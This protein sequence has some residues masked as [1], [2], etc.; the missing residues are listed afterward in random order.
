[1]PN[2]SPQGS[3]IAG[4]PGHMALRVERLTRDDHLHRISVCTRLQPRLELTAVM[5]AVCGL[6]TLRWLS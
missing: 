3:S 4:H 2:T 6:I 1:M 5:Y